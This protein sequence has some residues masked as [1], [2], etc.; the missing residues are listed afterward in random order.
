MRTPGWIASIFRKH[1]A[2]LFAVARLRSFL[3]CD[4]R[5]GTATSAALALAWLVGAVV[6]D[7]AIANASHDKILLFAPSYFWLTIVVLMIGLQGI[8][9]LWNVIPFRR[10]GDLVAMFWWGWVG[11]LSLMPPSVVAPAFAY[12]TLMLGCGWS[13]V[14]IRFEI[15]KGIE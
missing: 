7:A 3:Y 5:S 4:T 11:V 13:F 8:G 1:P 6:D 14:T 15:Q 2:S 9:A 10:Y 12:F